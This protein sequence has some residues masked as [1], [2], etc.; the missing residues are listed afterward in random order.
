MVAKRMQAGFTLVEMVLSIAIMGVLA[1]ASSRFLV[2]STQVYQGNAQYSETL[3][4]LRYA[5]DRIARE[6]REATGGTNANF[7]MSATSPQYSRIDYLVSN[8]NS[9]TRNTPTVTIGQNT[10]TKIVTIAYSTTG[11]TAQTLTN[12]L[13]SL[14]FAYYD[15]NFA[16]TNSATS[17][18]Y[19]DFTLALT[20]PTSGQAISQ[21][22]LV[23]L[24]N[25]NATLC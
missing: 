3:D 10:A 18:R 2:G 1:A 20:E 13:Q 25:C 11:N 22:T 5:S 24:R 7:N 17:V 6:L 12:R 23:A 9:M 21:R 8:G 19:I 14:S 16:T 4:S 15:T